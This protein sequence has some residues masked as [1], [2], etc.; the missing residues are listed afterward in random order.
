MREIE[1]KSER[2]SERDREGEWE[3]GRE[4][5]EDSL[6]KGNQQMWCYYF[7]NAISKINNKKTIKNVNRS[8]NIFS[9]NCSKIMHSTHILMSFNWIYVHCILIL[10]I[11]WI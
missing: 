3:R 2:E 5:E 6:E 7:V 1:K 9:T 8:I 10:N 4:R 11:E